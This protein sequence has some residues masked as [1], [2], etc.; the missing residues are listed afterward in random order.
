MARPE[1]PSSVYLDSNALIY[2]IVK[3]PGH[4]PIAE[5][6]RLAQA[7]KLTVVISTLSYVDVRGWGRTDPYPPD[8]DRRCIDVLDDP[9]LLRVEFT[10]KVAVNA[11]RVAYTYGLKNP[12]AIHLASAVE[13]GVD[14]LMTADMRFP[15]GQLVEGVWVDVPYE[16][17]PP[18]L[19]GT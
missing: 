1:N 10:R 11:R 7:D 17:G 8:L 18:V 6:L 3:R 12:D 4:E 13:A 2:A 9:R 14:V 5:V 15:H 19:P 16:P